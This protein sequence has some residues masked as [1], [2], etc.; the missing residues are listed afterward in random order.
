MPETHPSG[1]SLEIAA[2]CWCDQRT[3]V[4]VM[5]AELCR[6]FAEA[7]DRMRDEALEE[8]AVLTENSFIKH[9]G[10]VHMLEDKIRD[11]KSTAKNAYDSELSGLTREEGVGK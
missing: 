2:Q 5:D 9:E 8:A 4:H 7:L 3:Q 11:L 6:V 10:Y 1:R